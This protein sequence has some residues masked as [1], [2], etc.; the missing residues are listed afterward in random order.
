MMMKL[1]VALLLASAIS[2]AAFVPTSLKKTAFVQLQGYLDDL[3]DELNGPDANPDIEGESRENTKLDDAA[4]DRFGVG[5]WSSFVDFD[6][7]DGGDGQMGVAGDGKKGLDK[8][9][10]GASEMGKSKMR[11]AKN[12]WGKSTGYAEQLRDQGV[13]TSRAQQLENWHNQ[14]EVLQERKQQRYMTDDFD[15]VSEDE[16]WRKLGSFGVERNQD[17]DLD[18][19]FGAVTPGST[20]VDTVQLTSRLNQPK[21]YE[22]S[23]KN[24]FMGFSD[25]RAAFTPETSVEWTVEP[26]EG[27][28]AGKT[29][30]DFVLK[31]RPTNP[32]NSE[33]YLVI[34]TEDDK[35]TFKLEG[36]AS[37]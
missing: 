31:Y 10:D 34:D 29:F 2:S 11:S 7:F 33:G 5:D 26:T 21:V 18:T 4:K 19:E 1:S 35:W 20:F 25:F 24:S 22:F 28:L 27:S 8:E 23:L 32:G 9:W 17:F 36:S 15:K 12:A 13:E 16:D 30:T 37:M 6:E 14:Q 3:S